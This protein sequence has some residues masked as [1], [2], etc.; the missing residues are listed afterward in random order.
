MNRPIKPPALRLLGRLTSTP[1]VGCWTC[2]YSLGSHGRP[3]VGIGQT[4]VT[5]ARVV[6][7]AKLGR[8]LRPG[9]L[10]CHTCDNAL[11]VRPEH[12]YEGTYTENLRDALERG[13]NARG[14]AGR[15][16]SP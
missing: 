8:P 14:D 4:V 6:L 5:A 11:C 3:Q 15:F 10:A 9:L 16:V 1:E 12:V 13:Q 7:E 2:S